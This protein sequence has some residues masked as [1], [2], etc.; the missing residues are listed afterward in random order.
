MA[1]SWTPERDQIVRDGYAAGTPVR[2]LAKTLGIDISTVSKR[3]QTLGAR[4]TARAQVAQAV[5][6]K[7]LDAKARR[8]D[9][10]ARLYTRAE[11]VLARLEADT[12]RTLVPVAPGE[13]QP[14]NLD[15]VP[16]PDERYLSSS[17]SSYLSS[18]ERLEK[19]DADTGLTDAVGMLDKI[20]AEI[21]RVAD[22][23]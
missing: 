4:S 8:A 7:K 9:I 12:F 21:Q 1:S 18:A 10:L 6:A 14:R 22:T 15:F 20:A 11:T 17:L 16:P 5:A 23:C 3:A 19:L 2:Q 13:Q